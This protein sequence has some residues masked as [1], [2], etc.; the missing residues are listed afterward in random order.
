MDKQQPQQPGPDFQ[1]AGLL[2]LSNFHIRVDI[3]WQKSSFRVSKPGF[4]LHALDPK[5]QGLWNFIKVL[6]GKSGPQ[7]N[8]ID[9]LLT[10][11][12]SNYN[13]FDTP[14][15]YCEYNNIAETNSNIHIISAV[16]CRDI[17][18]HENNFHLII[19]FINRHFVVCHKKLYPYSTTR[20]EIQWRGNVFWTEEG[21]QKI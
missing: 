1:V 8:V 20:W 11:T 15:N 14:K 18:I 4:Y 9:S 2:T 12:R 3:Y 10:K 5:R 21:A 16:V 13:A 6:Y 7:R 19:N 17:K